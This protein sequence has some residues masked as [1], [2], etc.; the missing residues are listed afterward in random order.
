[1]TFKPAKWP[2]KLRSQE[3]F[4]GTSK[5]AIYHRSW[6]KNQGLPADL[7]DGR[8]VIGILNTFSELNPCNAHLND[9]AERVK[10]GVYEAGGFPVIVPVFSVSESG[11]RPTAMMVRNLAAMSIEEQLRGLPIDGAVLMVGC[12]KTTP[13]LL[14]AAASC[15]VPSI[16]VTGGPM[17]NGWFRGERVGSGTHMWK[18]S[19]AVRAGT[20]TTDDFIEAEAAMSRSAGS[21][22][23]MGTASTMASMAEA[24]GMALSGNA[25]IPAVDS[26]RRMMAQLTGRRIVQMVK[27]DLKPSDILTKQ[28][29]ENAIRT[30]A[31]LL[32]TSDAADE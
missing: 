21:C 4:A 7:F 15:D 20:M 26:R 10:H 30:N 27:D 17:L 11:F 5:D 24:L 31:C 3:W 1:M 32:Y 13:S 28:A 16:V 18:F 23:T 22:N 8:P 19:E 2:R 9:L 6:M 12:D 14:M 29:F 25:A